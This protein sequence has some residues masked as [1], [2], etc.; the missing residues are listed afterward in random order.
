ML[1]KNDIRNLERKYGFSPQK[2]LGQSFLTDANIKD[3]LLKFAD[4]GKSDILI[5]IGS[6][7]GQLTFDLSKAAKK[8]IAIEFDRKLFSI[9]TDFAKDFTNIVLVHDDF[10]KFN[11]KDFIPKNK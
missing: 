7:L 11:L 1:N 8:V 2:K 6:G 9:L 4:I 3:K 5:E 10:L